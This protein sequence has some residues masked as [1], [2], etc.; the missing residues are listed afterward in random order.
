MD[1][2]MM[3]DFGKMV[4][5]K[6]G[7]ITECPL[8]KVIGKLKY[9]DVKTMYDVERYNGRR[10]IMGREEQDVPRPRPIKR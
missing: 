10:T 1:L 4:C 3:I 7:R 9:V 6:N 2:V 5:Y 8:E